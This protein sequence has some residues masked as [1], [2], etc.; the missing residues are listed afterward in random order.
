[1]SDPINSSLNSQIVYGWSGG[2]EGK[3][4]EKDGETHNLTTAEEVQ[5]GLGAAEEALG[6]KILQDNKNWLRILGNINDAG[7][8]DLPTDG[9][10]TSAQLAAAINSLNSLFTNLVIQGKD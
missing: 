7:L 1:M 9:S 8:T 2:V 10:A 6:Q 5:Q 3:E 4:F